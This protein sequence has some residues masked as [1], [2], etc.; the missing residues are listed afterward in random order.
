[1]KPKLLKISVAPEQSFSCRFESV[2]FFYSEWH[3]HPEIELVYIQQGTGTQFIGNN[4]A[5]FSNDDLILVGS[6]LPHLWK[7]DEKYFEKK[8]DINAQSL[9]IHFLPNVFGDYFLKLPENKLLADLQ[10]KAKLGLSIKG[11]TKQ[12]VLEKMRLL[13]IAKGADRVIL[14]LDILNKIALSNEI[15]TI[16]KNN[17]PHNFSVKEGERMNTIFQ[18]LINN[19]SKEIS[20]EDIAAKANL[21]PNAFCRFFKSRTKKTF[22]TFLIE[23]RINYACKLLAESEKSVGNICIQSGFNNAA[24]FNRYF[25]Q[26]TNATPLEYRKKQLEK[27]F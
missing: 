15:V 26:I 3:F 27:S 24:H 16:A 21:S 12:I 20:L 6:N 2:P 14:L 11:Y 25:K 7:C 19:F 8:A 5:H 1:M 4:V 18:Y 10:N 23:M 22:S 17:I 9:V 13:L